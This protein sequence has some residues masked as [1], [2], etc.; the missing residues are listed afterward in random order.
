MGDKLV[1]CYNLG[2]GQKFN[3]AENNDGE[4][5]WVKV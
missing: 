1:H 3:P 5:N 2:C 4:L